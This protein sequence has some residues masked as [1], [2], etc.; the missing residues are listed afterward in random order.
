VT[1]LM[2]SRGYRRRDR[3]WER[4]DRDRDRYN[5]RSG[6][7]GD[8]N[9]DG[10]R[11]S[12]SRS[13]LRGERERRGGRS[14]LAYFVNRSDSISDRRPH[15]RGKGDDRWDRERRDGD[16]RD[17]RKRD[18]RRRDDDRE[19]DVR[20]EEHR[21]VESKSLKEKDTPTRERSPPP[22]RRVIDIRLPL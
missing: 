18:E 13:P 8:G 7:G 21:S 1:L 14:F 20:R 4:D 3:S 16:R 11:R 19:R 9:R 17:G 12:R 10:S 22:S 2:S 6:R 5:S 15:E